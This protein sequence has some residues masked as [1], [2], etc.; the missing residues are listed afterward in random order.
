MS[1]HLYGARRPAEIGFTLIEVMIVVAIIAILAAIAM[2]Q[3]SDYITR[4]RMQEAQ[5]TLA[6]MRVRMEQYFQDNR[7]YVGACAV[8]TVAPLPDNTPSWT[9]TCPVLTAN[10]YTVAATGA[11]PMAA[12]AFDLDQANVRRTTAAASGWAAGPLPSNCWIVA[13]GHC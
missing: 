4:S 8:G 13:K 2:P 11:G 7:T 3:Y 12:F 10:T 1:A 6:N 5:A 9:Y